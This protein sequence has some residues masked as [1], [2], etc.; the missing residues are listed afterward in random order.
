MFKK[1]DQLKSQLDSHRPLPGS[2]VKNLRDDLIL[3]WW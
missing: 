3:R 2:V 1:I